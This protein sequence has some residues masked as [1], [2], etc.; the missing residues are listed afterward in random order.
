MKYSLNGR[1]L[2]EFFKLLHTTY[3][4]GPAGVTLLRLSGMTSASSTRE[5]GS[6]RPSTEEV[7]PTG[8]SMGPTSSTMLEDLSP[9]H[10]HRVESFLCLSTIQSSNPSSHTSETW[11]FH[12]SDHQSSSLS[13]SFLSYSSIHHP[14]HKKLIIL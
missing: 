14:R 6:L 2:E 13:R 11:K 10:P 3:L 8:P 9:H 12:K 7:L 1:L 5:R 4:L